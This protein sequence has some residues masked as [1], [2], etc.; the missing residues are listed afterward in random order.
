M[1]SGIIES[2]QL[3]EM[4]RSGFMQ[5]NLPKRPS[6]VSRYMNGGINKRDKYL[7]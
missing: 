1:L 6:K 5:D 3:H 2:D 4:C 7:L